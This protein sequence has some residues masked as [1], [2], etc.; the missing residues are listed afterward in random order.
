MKEKFI[1]FERYKFTGWAKIYKIYNKV[2]NE[3]CNVN[4]SLQN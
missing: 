2:Y 1:R 4:K 3:V